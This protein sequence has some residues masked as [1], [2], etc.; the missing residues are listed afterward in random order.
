MPRRDRSGEQL[1]VDGLTFRWRAAGGRVEV[2][3]VLDA[4]RLTVQPPVPLESRPSVAYVT[5]AVRRALAAGWRTEDHHRILGNPALAGSRDPHAPIDLH[6]AVEWFAQTDLDWGLVV[7]GVVPDVDPFCVRLYRDTL[8]IRTRAERASRPIDPEA[9]ADLWV[10]AARPDDG[11]G[12]ELRGGSLDAA[13]ARGAV[14]PVVALTGT[15]RMARGLAWPSVIQTVLDGLHGPLVV[16]EPRWTVR[17]RVVRVYGRLEELDARSLLNRVQDG[18]WVIDARALVQLDS[19]WVRA[20]NRLA[21]R[22]VWL[23]DR[24]QLVDRMGVVAEV[25]RSEAAALQRLSERA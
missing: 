12:T 21:A 4:G 22:L 10:A 8:S 15:W 2:W 24:E 11:R 19:E 16:P 20:L 17:G 1:S 14:D 18:A 13:G 6:D 23:G 7:V 25:H 9:A 5:D 3:H